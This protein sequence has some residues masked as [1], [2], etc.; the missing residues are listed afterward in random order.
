MRGSAMAV[1][2][3]DPGNHGPMAARD[4]IVA[5]TIAGASPQRLRPKTQRERSVFADL[6]LAPTNGANDCGPAARLAITGRA[7]TQAI[8][9]SRANVR[10]KS[11][12]ASA[13][14]CD[15]AALTRRPRSIDRSADLLSPGELR[16]VHGA[17]AIPARLNVIVFFRQRSCL[18]PAPLLRA[19][20]LRALPLRALLLRTTLLLAP[21]PLSGCAGGA[22]APEPAAP[23]PPALA[24]AASGPQ[25][26]AVANGA[27]RPAGR[28]S[29]WFC[30]EGQ[31]H[32]ATTPPRDRSGGANPSSGWQ[33]IETSAPHA[34]PV[35]PPRT[36]PHAAAPPDAAPP[37]I[38]RGS[39]TAITPAA[40]VHAT[41][42]PDTI[43]PERVRVDA[44]GVT[45]PGYTAGAGAAV[46]PTPRL[47]VLEQSPDAWA[48]QLIATSSRA[49]LE[50]VAAQHNL[51]AH[52]AVRLAAGKTVRY[53]L[54]WD[55]YP[56][57]ATALAALAALPA[58][59]RA[60]QP[61]V[62][63]VG[64]LQQA[65]NDAVQINPQARPKTPSTPASRTSARASRG[66]KAHPP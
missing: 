12:V 26:S 55:V 15:G 54:V 66:K 51:Y 50:R 13:V 27:A 29:D 36:S 33:C 34:T 47:R 39:D 58:P 41:N 64:A 46:A 1:G 56:D 59:L 48:I 21:L 62:R 44:G 61:W 28:P 32:G 52:P 65:M 6:A 45:I 18:L 31:R 8:A 23:P 4:A 11:E 40:A 38:E 49:A 24:D 10:R 22:A 53:A 37:G 14:S 9:Q 3:E 42:L 35:A 2:A 19:P 60:L 43:A 20:L 16:Y 57:R 25:P 5:R 30:T 17:P 7:I 63:Q